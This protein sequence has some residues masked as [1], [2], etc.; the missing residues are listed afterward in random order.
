MKISFKSLEKYYPYIPAILI[1]TVGLVLSFF[2]WASQ[3][4]V[5][6]LKDTMIISEFIRAGEWFG[7]ESVGEHGFISK[8]ITALFF[9]ITG[10][11]IWVATFFNIILASITAF[12]MHKVF[13]HFTKNNLYAML[14]VILAVFSYYYVAVVPKYLRDIP[15]MFAL[16]LF[17]YALIKEKPF[18]LLG[19]LFMLVLDAKEYIAVILTPVLLIWLP[20]VEYQKNKFSFKTIWNIGYKSVLLF[21]PAIIFLYLMFFTSV[22]PVNNFMSAFLKLTATE[23]NVAKVALDKQKLSFG[24]DTSKVISTIKIETEIINED[25]IKAKQ[26]KTANYVRNL[27][28]VKKSLAKREAQPKRKIKTTEIKK[29][30]IVKK[31]NIV[32]KNVASTK[33]SKPK[34]KLE[35]KKIPTSKKDISKKDNKIDKEKILVKNEQ[36]NIDTLN[37]EKLQDS[38][39]LSLVK[40]ET[41][42]EAKTV[43]NKQKLSFGTDTSKVIS[44]IKIE[45]EIINEDSIKAKQIKT[46]NYVRNLEPVKK[47][48][49]KREAQPKRKIKTT[50][51]KKNDIVKKTNIVDK[52]VASTKKSKPKEKLEFKKIPTSKKDIS[53]KDNKIDKEKIL[54]KNEQQNIDTLNTEKLQDSSKLS[55]VKK[56]TKAEAK[57][58]DNKQ[59]VKKNDTLNVDVSSQSIGKVDEDNEE[60]LKEENFAKLKM[61]SDSLRAERSEFVNL[62]E[63]YGISILNILIVY[64]QKMLSP[65]TFSYMS[66]PLYLIIFSL[67]ACIALLI[68]NFKRPDILFISI[69]LFMYL[70][71]YLIRPSHARYLLHL[72]PIFSLFVI[73]F[74][75]DSLDNYKRILIPVL[76]TMPI[77][78]ATL[79]YEITM[80]V[81]K[82]VAH[83][84]FY[85]LLLLISYFAYKHNKLWAKRTSIAFILLLSFFTFGSA[86]VQSI[87]QGQIIKSLTFGQNN[88]YKEIAKYF[89]KNKTYWFNGDSYLIQFYNKDI[90]QG[91]LPWNIRGSNLLK[92]WL[93]KSNLET[94]LNYI[95]NFY[96]H[97]GLSRPDLMAKYN[98]DYI[99]LI[100]STKPDLKTFPYVGTPNAN[101]ETFKE[102]LLTSP[103]WLEL[104][105][106]VELKNKE[107]YIYKIKYEE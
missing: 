57:T 68:K 17:I 12:I 77:T 81:V 46:A 93:P 52:N 40:K 3:D 64:G 37:T 43:D 31:T 102:F 7:N 100:Y 41:K 87:T 55:L 94:K 60:N 42:A 26:I 97:N 71:V 8:L 69:Y 23:N 34:E 66:F 45:T 18:W 15:V 99:A 78:A 2:R 54:V 90:N 24:T 82:L 22:V 28:P 95:P 83:I 49:A 35:F 14:A 10:P 13:Y 104:E 67:I 19:L 56:E 75:L 106:K 29:N 51:I 62:L 27:E 98:T 85:S 38:S 107:L 30:D 33:K 4:E 91:I 89:D 96:F 32:D 61:S 16:L 48:L 59:K 5:A 39:K 47:S 92:E 105:K 84:F 103:E 53:K 80:P 20:L 9:L 73:Y 86:M 1:F 65:R 25:S 36:Q 50:E 58:V 6:Y 72:V 74:L 70:A 44:T 21:A 11:N 101:Q 63:Y 88:E 79:Y 76:I